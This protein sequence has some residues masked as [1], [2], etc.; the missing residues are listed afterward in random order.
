MKHLLLT[1]LLAL[2][3]T[4]FALEDRVVAVV[5]SN[6]ITEGQVQSRTHLRIQQLGLAS[7]TQPQ[8]QQI[9]KRTLGDMIDEELQRQYA[10]AIGMQLPDDMLKAAMADVLRNTPAL[11]NLNARDMDS[12]REQVRAELRWGQITALVVKPQIEISNAETDQII[13]DMTKSRHVLERDIS[14]IFAAVDETNE[15]A[16]RTRME[17]ILNQLKN[18]ADFATLARTSSD[19]DTSASAGG[20]MGWFASGELNPQLEEAL[21]QLKPSELSGLIRTPLGFHIVRLDNVRTTKAVDTAPV[22]ELNLV[23]VGRP[24][25]VS[26]TESAAY[27]TLTDTVINKLRKPFQVQAALADA[28]FL[29]QWPASNSLGWVNAANL[30]P[31]VQQLATT[32]QPGQWTEPFTMDGK[33]TAMYLATT[34]QTTS[35]QL[36]AYRERVKEHLLRNRLELASRRLMRDLRAKAFVD[37]RW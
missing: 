1:C 8:T 16:A 2:A 15:A 21:N 3:S 36:V 26:E 20:H 13:A 24:F 34:R 22:T 5:N 32:L 28:T 27:T 33:A 29:Q 35:P 30:Q 9:A 14:Q 19:D 17:D 4:T 11:A 12:M 7:P 18:G 31:A 37:I 10:E 23:V 6:I 25:A